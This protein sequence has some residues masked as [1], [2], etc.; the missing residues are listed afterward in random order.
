M[1]ESRPRG[2][3]SGKANIR[4]TA[5]LSKGFLGFITTGVESPSV[6]R[7]GSSKKLLHS[8]SHKRKPFWLAELQPVKVAQEPVTQTPQCCCC[9]DPHRGLA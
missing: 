5:A 3:G 7:S 1:L 4:P 8:Q 9:C 6:Y 2:T